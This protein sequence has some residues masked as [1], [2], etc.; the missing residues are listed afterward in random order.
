LET[1]VADGRIADASGLESWLRAQIAMGSLR[2]E[3]ILVSLVYR[4][5]DE[6]TESNC[7]DVANA[8][9]ASAERLDEALTVGD[10]FRHAYLDGWA[11]ERSRLAASVYPRIA[12][13]AA[14][15]LAARE[16]GLPLHATLEAYAVAAQ[17]NLISAGIR[18]SL[19]GQR[20]GQRIIAR[21][22]PDA[23]NAAVLALQATEDDLGSATIAAD[24]SAMR[25]ETQTVRLFRS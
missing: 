10:A 5:E 6:Q 19:I 18:L 2:N 4:A 15:G 7:I 22:Q 9:H 3:L 1:A 13:P 20:D 25:H 8:L 23:R 17:T 14:V 16:R 21:L 24:I 12:Y 11:D